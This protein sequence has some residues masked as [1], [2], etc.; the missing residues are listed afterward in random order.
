MET[1]PLANMLLAARYVRIVGHGNSE[2]GP[3]GWNSIAEIKVLAHR[4]TA[5]SN[6]GPSLCS[7][8]DQTAAGARGYCLCI[9]S[10]GAGVCGQ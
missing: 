6:L 1:Y 10:G 5:P 9:T 7:D 3:N 8:D 2:Q 4:P